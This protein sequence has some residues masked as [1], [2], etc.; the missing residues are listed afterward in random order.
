MN[1]RPVFESWSGLAPHWERIRAAAG[2]VV[3]TNGCFDLLHAGHVAY[4]EEARSLGDFLFLGLNGDA[5]V[6]RLKGETRPILPFAER[7]AILAGLRA[8]DL[9][10]GFEEDTPLALIGHVQPDYLVKGGDW[11]PEQI[12][13]ADLV[14]ARGGR[15]ESLR[16]KPGSST[17]N[18]VATILARHA[19]LRD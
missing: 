17:T 5:S 14:L 8:V 4:L 2:R 15:V 11:R 1:D 10:C 19:S 6:R 7:A 16:F 12:V 3:F 13:G 9:I 18:I